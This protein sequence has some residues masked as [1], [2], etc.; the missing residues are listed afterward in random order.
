M[1]VKGLCSYPSMFKMAMVK[2]LKK[3][4]K[5]IVNIVW[6]ETKAATRIWSIIIMW[7]GFI[8]GENYIY[9]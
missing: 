6:D 2:K 5:A 1:Y 9:F 4:T 3:N 8:W 7:L